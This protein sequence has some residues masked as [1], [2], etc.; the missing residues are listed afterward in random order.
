MKMFG[1]FFG[2][3]GAAALAIAAALGL[4]LALAGCSNSSNSAALLALLG[5]GAGGKEAASI[6]FSAREVDKIRTDAAFTNE[7]TNSGDGA[8]TYESSDTGVAT[9]DAA[10]GQ[11]TI[12]AE[13]TTTI[14][15]TVADSE[16]YSY[17]QK[18]ASY[19]L[20]VY[21]QY[22]AIPL[23]IEPVLGG[24]LIVEV[25]NAPPSFKYFIDGDGSTEL[26][27]LKGQADPDNAP[28]SIQYPYKLYFY[29]DMTY[30]QPSKPF[31]LYTGNWDC[32]VYGNV[33]SLLD[34]K[35]FISL[36][37]TKI[38]HAFA[39]LFKDNINMKNHDDASKPLLLPA[40]T[41]TD[42]C[43]YYMFEG[44]KSLTKAPDL[45][46]KTMAKYSYHHMFYKCE[47]LTMTPALQAEK[48]AEG[49]YYGMFMDCVGLTNNVP[50]DLLPVRELAKLCYESMFS[51]CSNLAS[52]P[53]LPSEELQ[54]SCYCQMFAGCKKIVTAPTL[55]A[56]TLVKNCY[57]RMF[58]GCNELKVVN[59]YA[60]NIGAEGCLDDW[61]LNVS[62]T[63]TFTKHN[64]IV[65]W[66]RDENGIPSGWD[67]EQYYE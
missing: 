58:Q 11:V 53:S 12:V 33:N 31:R 59:C 41:L 14:T 18:T 34:S 6:R 46:A 35:K 22:M 55:T 56:R 23:T 57:A 16:T 45:P 36:K 60:T 67:V 47:G 2:G 39:C 42:D 13:G 29:A 20:S 4:A 51:G 63:G 1:K 54:E 25:K 52:P 50:T 43:Y 61:L 38:D 64:T 65:P 66:T 26:R 15:A 5:G 9:V 24:T 28:I 17:A 10:T 37:T 44:C 27:D 3:R 7:L 32:Y 8:V 49:C 19:T 21:P 62:N 30:N 40:T 48:L